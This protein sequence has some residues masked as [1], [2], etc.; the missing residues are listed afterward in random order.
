MMAG[1]LPQ[2]K[3]SF[4][5]SFFGN[6][7]DYRFVRIHKS[8]LIP[9]VQSDQVSMTPWGELY[10]PNE[11][12]KND[13]SII[14]SQ[15][16]IR[17]LHHFIHEISHVWQYQRKKM[18]SR[19]L[20]V[21]CG[22]AYAPVT[23]VAQAIDAISESLPNALAEI[24]KDI[25]GAIDPYTY[26][27]SSPKDFFEYN[28]ESQAEI[29]ADYFISEIMGQKGYTGKSSNRRIRVDFFYEKTLENFLEEIDQSN[30]RPRD[31]KAQWNLK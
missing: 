17:D 26:K 8:K 1:G 16:D 12:Y 15:L 18:L 4:A 10:M 23:G 11:N 22:A 31:L 5:K 30:R 29:L 27:N 28:M 9:G 13:F 25:S 7:I 2:V 21:I 20:F 14:K 6:A 24:G 3:L 19:G